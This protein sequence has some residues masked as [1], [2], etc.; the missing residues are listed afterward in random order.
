MT[1]KEISIGLFV[2]AMFSQL[3][4]EVLSRDYVAKTAQLIIKKH[5]KLARSHPSLIRDGERL[6]M[7]SWDDCQKVLDQEVAVTE[8]IKMT[9]T[10]NPFLIKRYK[11]N[12]KKLERLYKAFKTTD[13]QF[14]SS[15]AVTMFAK[16][17]DENIAQLNYRS[18][19]DNVS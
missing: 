12:P 19:H 15:R 6:A 8:I 16:K 2:D 5:M 7:Q 9:I 4:K 13:L 11:L 10:R 18:N 1:L 3:P 17:L 14:R